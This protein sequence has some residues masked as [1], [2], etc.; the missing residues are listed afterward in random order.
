MSVRHLW[1]VAAGEVPEA[2]EAVVTQPLADLQP[3]PPGQDVYQLA[4][5]DAGFIM[6][7]RRNP[8]APKR[9]G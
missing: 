7:A 6:S 2:G 3:M 1:I 8:A 4:M 5:I 9:G